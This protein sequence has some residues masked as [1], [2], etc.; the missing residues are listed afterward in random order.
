MSRQ[1]TLG[2]DKL[3]QQSHVA[4]QSQEHRVEIPGS[5]P[6]LSP[7]CQTNNVCLQESTSSYPECSAGYSKGYRE[8]TGPNIIENVFPGYS[9]YMIV[10]D[11]YNFCGTPDSQLLPAKYTSKFHAELVQETPP[12]AGNTKS[13]DSLI[14]FS[15]NGCVNSSRIESW[16]SGRPQSGMMN[17]NGLVNLPLS[18]NITTTVPAAELL[19]APSRRSNTFGSNSREESMGTYFPDSSIQTDTMQTLYLMNP[20]VAGYTDSVASGNM[21]LLNNMPGNA[22]TTHNFV[23]NGQPQQ[24]FIEINGSAASRSQHSSLGAVENSAAEHSV[25]SSILTSAL[26]AHTYNSWHG[27]GNG[28]TFQQ[29]TDAASSN[30]SLCGQLNNCAKLD[31]PSVAEISQL[32]M[33]HPPMSSIEEQQ[34]EILTRGLQ[35]QLDQSSTATGQRQELSLRLSPQH[36]STVQ[37]PSFQNH[38]TDLDINCP[39]IAQATSEDNMYGVDGANRDGMMRTGFSNSIHSPHT[40]KRIPSSLNMVAE[41]PNVLRG[42]KYLKAAQELLDEV[43]SLGKFG[44]QDYAKHHKSH[45]LCGSRKDKENASTEE[46][47][48]DGVVDTRNRHRASAEEADYPHNTELTPAERQE[49][50]IKKAK[51]AAMLDEVDRKYRQYYHQMQIVVSSF[52]AVTEVGAAK[53]Y[54]SVALQT[55]SRQFRCLRDAITGQIRVVGKSLG[56]EEIPE[57]CKGE[58]SRLRFMDQQLRQQRALQ[59]LGM[60]QHAW[61][62]QR[63]LPER[64][65][66]V[67]RAWLFEHFLHPYPKDSDKVMLAR[68]A[69]LTRSQVSNWFINARVRLWKPMVEEMYMEENKEAEL[70]HASTEKHNKENVENKEEVKSDEGPGNSHFRQ[71]Q[72]HTVSHLG[73]NIQDVVCEEQNMTSGSFKSEHSSDSNYNKNRTLSMEEAS[74]EEVIREV[75]DEGASQGQLKKAR[76]GIEDNAYQFAPNIFTMLNFKLEESCPSD[77][78][79]NK[80]NEGRHNN[81]DYS[82]VQNHMF[83]ADVNGSSGAYQLGCI[84]GY[85]QDSFISRFSGSG[86]VSLTL[87]LQQS[88]GVSFSRNQQS[89]IS[90]Q[91]RTSGTGRASDGNCN[92][93]E[94]GVAH[95]AD[96]YD[97]I[98]LQN[99]EHYGSHPM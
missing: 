98:S 30:Q 73:S 82:V 60:I 63:G 36:P 52:E 23:G 3:Q 13:G 49:L 42:C 43:V 33:R 37:V 45:S 61:R 72:K 21:V 39:G 58:T 18:V 20:G 41:F 69:G 54:T 16:D 93:M 24:H 99:R 53:T 97:S 64:S 40:S 12:L 59:Q 55:I 75:Q 86:G 1:S 50:Q 74:D 11:P 35:L 94:T 6:S 91:G 96:G 57:S 83:L 27:R 38:H 26:G 14:P 2:L 9:N 66:S 28:M 80:F 65:V 5:E 70:G 4:E 22:L 90:N 76:N 32:G 29:T 19:A 48:K 10:S 7:Q 92:I 81:E 79:D 89:C 67:L 46:G 71:E 85:E 95:A 84:N 25:T 88:D 68:Q 77:T 51:L 34:P 87:G 47:G 62:P 17:N 15:F 44:K 56:E 8:N 31:N 78:C